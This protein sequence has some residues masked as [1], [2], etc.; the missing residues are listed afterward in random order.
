MTNSW[1]PT[2]LAPLLSTPNTTDLANQPSSSN[3]IQP[4]ASKSIK[5]IDATSIHRITSG[6][7]VVDL[8]GAVKELVENSLD[9]GAGLVGRLLFFFY[10]AIL[11]SN[12]WL[13]VEVRLTN[14]GLDSI[15]VIDDGSGI[16]ENDWETVGTSNPSLLFFSVYQCDEQLSN[17]TPPNLPLTLTWK[18]Y[19]RLV[20]EARRSL[21]C[22]EYAKR[23]S[24]LTPLWI[25]A[26][27]G[28]PGNGLDRHVFYC[29]NGDYSPA[30]W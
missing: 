24:L 4:S 21:H 26:N 3:Q 8:Q 20:L 14:Y 7:V 2:P 27:E 23:Y 5:P 15:T 30:G 6:Q 13:S 19:G 22:V 12:G 10:L 29:A 17:I 1:T 28:V 9:A 25:Y 16:A 18:N 11:F